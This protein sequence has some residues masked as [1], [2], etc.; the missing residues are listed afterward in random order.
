ML[1]QAQTTENTPNTRPA[2]L[3]VRGISCAFD[4]FAAVRGLSLEIAAG[5]V[6]CLLGAS[7]C[8][9]TTTLRS[10]AGVEQPHEG[11][12][13]IDGVP[14][15]NDQTFI[16]PEARHVGLMFQ[17]Y[18]L[19]PHMTV[20]ANV[21]FGLTHLKKRDRK[22]RAMAALAQ[23]R[24]ADHAKQYP[25]QLSGGEQQRVGLARALA[26]EPAVML[27]DEPF[28]GLDRSLRHSI[29][30]EALEALKAS[31]TAVLLVTHDPEE[32]LRAGDRIAVMQAGQILQC[33][34]PEILQQKP[35]D[36]AVASLFGHHNVLHSFTQAGQ[37]G[38][39]LGDFAAPGIA[40]DT[41]VEVFFR[42]ADV[43]LCDAGAGAAATVISARMMGEA[44]LVEL[45]I[46]ATGEMLEAI[47]NGP[48]VIAPGAKVGVRNRGRLVPV[49]PCAQRMA[50]A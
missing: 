20:L 11:E 32:A 40:D 27:M 14:V 42:P 47:H 39:P 30:R 21:M 50:D 5:E 3:V 9:K 18:A 7:G 31:G 46:D 28:S 35:A 37:A 8:G 1:Q 17:D 25:H 2:R 12:I 34:T 45:T 33:D 6:L 22:A 26:P 24:M 44:T 13:L 4:G 41:E 19:F 36:P 16:S 10:V 29:R 48:N 15:S 23:V 43:E 49:F 38:T